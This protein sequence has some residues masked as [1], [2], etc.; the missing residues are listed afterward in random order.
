MHIYSVS[1]NKTCVC[2]A[3]VEGL[4]SGGCAPSPYVHL[5]GSELWRAPVLC[6]L[7]SVFSYYILVLF[8]TDLGI[9]LNNHARERF[10]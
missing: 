8:A 7:I 2:F 6:F 1:I 10:Q 5:R 9:T 3:G 4:Q